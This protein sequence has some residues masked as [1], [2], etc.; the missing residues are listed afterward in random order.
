MRR[1][2][3]ATLC[4]GLLLALLGLDL[5]QARTLNIR[6]C[7]Q[8]QDLWCWA[9]A[10]QAILGYYR[11]NRTQP[12]I[13]QYGT[14][15]LNI[16]NWLWGSSSNPTRRGIDLI[17]H[18]FGNLS[19]TT[20]SDSLTQDA[21]QAAINAGKPFV[22]RWGWDSGG[23][24]FVVA[25]GMTPSSASPPGSPTMY[26]MDPWYGPTVN[27]YAWVKKG[28]SHTWTDTLSVNTPPPPQFSP[29]PELRL[30]LQ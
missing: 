15:G 16:D 27:T 3:T 1:T 11:V 22:V 14:E 13:A 21:A 6:Q 9:G 26:I 29:A 24:H 23:G 8:E 4:L 17:L 28:S 5:A 2:L 30:L 19:T 18:N 7:Y 12:Q 20:L 25:R 10:S